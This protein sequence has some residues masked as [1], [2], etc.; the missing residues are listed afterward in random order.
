MA[1]V[2]FTLVA[3]LGA[4]HTL[5]A[6][7]RPR[8]VF[9]PQCNTLVVQASEGV[10]SASFSLGSINT[11]SD[12]VHAPF[13]LNAQLALIQSNNGS[14]Q[15][16]DSLL[17]G[18]PPAPPG[19]TALIV[20]GLQDALGSSASS[21]LTDNA[22]IAAVGAANSSMTTA[23]ESAQQAVAANFNANLLHCDLRLLRSGDEYLLCVALPCLQPLTLTYVGH[24]DPDAG[25][26]ET[27]DV[28]VLSRLRV[29][30]SLRLANPIHTITS[31]LLDTGCQLQELSVS[32]L[33][34]VPDFAAYREAFPSMDISF[35]PIIFMHVVF[36]FV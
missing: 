28:P 35:S 20:S 12:L 4:F 9:S 8:A 21:L 23:F 1:R 10:S 24:D 36:G 30:E 15:I 25:F 31:F 27:F 7:L 33:K 14:T 32:G 34:A 29:S 6:P 18:A 17:D 26:L 22:T 2:L 5:A 16:F 13:I 19:A 3:L 11:A